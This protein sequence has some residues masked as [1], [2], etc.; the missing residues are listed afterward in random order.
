MLPVGPVPPGQD[1]EQFVRRSESRFGMASPQHQQLLAQSRVFQQQI[2]A[3][4]DETRNWAE[5]QPQQAKHGLTS[6][7]EMRALPFIAKLLPQ[8]RIRVLASDTSD[9]QSPLTG[10][11]E[12][13]SAR[14]RSSVQNGGETQRRIIRWL[15]YQ[16]SI[17][18]R[19]SI[20]PS[21][22]R[23]TTT[24]IPVRMGSESSPSTARQ[25]LEARNTVW[26]AIR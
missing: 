23:F 22:A 16:H 21:T 7:A 13:N 6:V 17:R 26:S 24:K 15:R 19:P 11:G 3:G 18:I 14:C 2:A 1:P 12:Y 8:E 9:N 4:A 20:R 5:G 25:A 10:L